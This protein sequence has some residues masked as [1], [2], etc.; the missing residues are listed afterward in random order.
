[1]QQRFFEQ[2]PAKLHNLYGPTEAAVDVTYWTCTP[3]TKLASIPIGRPI[4]NI[5]IYILDRFLQPVPV[6]I[7]GELHIGGIGL[8]RGYLNRPELT[9]E[10]FIQ[11]PYGKPEDR[12]Y[13]TGDLARFLP[14]GNVEYLGRIDQQVKVRGFRIELG[15]IESVL[16]EHPDVVQAVVVARNEGGGEKSLLACIV[17]KVLSD[18][19]ANSPVTPAQLRVYLQSRLPEYMVP[20]AFTMLKQIPMT[21]SGKADRRALLEMNFAPVQ[22]EVAYIPP[23]TPLEEEVAAV[24]KEVLGLAQVGVQENFF[25]IGGHSLKATK[26]VMLLRNKLGINA[27]LR[28]L[29]E[30]ATIGEMSEALMQLLLDQA[31]EPALAE[32]IREVESLSD[33]EIDQLRASNAEQRAA[34]IEPPLP[35]PAGTTQS[36][37][38]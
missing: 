35:S 13:K 24:W 21:S 20:A 10:K 30:H 31:E 34:E 7:P 3:T 11:N 38:S 26:V 27:S 15:E 17:P 16:E 8:A 14:D 36:C 33:D 2:L 37:S 12:L 18:A 32:M 1:M 5:Q 4:A 29:F 23:R 22:R 19:P 6:G 25:E 28:L 9:A